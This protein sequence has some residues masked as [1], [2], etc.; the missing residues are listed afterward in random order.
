M[1]S[2][3]VCARL[4]GNKTKEDALA[5]VAS[6]SKEEWAAYFDNAAEEAF[7][8]IVEETDPSLN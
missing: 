5:D 6:V 4:F 7:D 2:D 8:E 3:E 1:R